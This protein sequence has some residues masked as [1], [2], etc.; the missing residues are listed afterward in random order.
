MR[1]AIDMR[2]SQDSIGG[3]PEYTSMV[4]HY[5]TQMAREHEFVLFYSGTNVSVPD[6]VRESKNVQVYVHH[7]PNKITNSQLYFLGRPCL[8]RIIKKT[9]P[10]PIDAWFLPNLNF[11]ALSPSQRSVI[12]IHDVSFR[13]YPEFFSPKQRWWHRAVDP[14]K[15]LSRA[16]KVIAVS[17]H[18]KSDVMKEFGTPE[19]KI[20]VTHLGIDPIFKL[21]RDMSAYSLQ[22]RGRTIL[23]YAGGDPRKNLD[24][25]V[26]G[27]RLLRDN[28]PHSADVSLHIIGKKGSWTRDVMHE[29]PAI[30]HQDIHFHH[31]ISRLATVELMHGASLFVYPSF[32]EGFGLP[33]LEAMS[34][35]VPVITSPNS[36]MLETADDSAYFTDPYNPHAMMRAMD[37]LL[38][39]NALRTRLQEKGRRRINEYSWENTTSKTLA[40]LEQ[41][42]TA[43]LNI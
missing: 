36:A 5:C 19:S 35:G 29:M 1:F 43:P 9:I 7:M 24:V 42:V 8:D 37:I 2:S 20:S 34:A 23:T 21:P 41:A 32:Y 13:R 33:L 39:N 14:Q 22:K 30:Y 11:V 26:G 15:L 17:E 6:W 4:A 40:V 28:I 16:Q 12:T 25:V 18:T 27:F 31:G 10:L 3:I 38:T